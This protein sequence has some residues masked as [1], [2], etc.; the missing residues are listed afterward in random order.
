[1]QPLILASTSPFRRELLGKLGLP[2]QCASPDIDE[3]RHTDEQPA[4]LVARLAEQKAKAVANNHPNSLIIGS[5]QVAILNKQILGKPGNHTRATQ[6]LQQASGKIITFLTGLSLYNTTS[7][8]LQTDVVP[9][10]VYFRKLTN[11]QIESYLQKEQPYNCAGSFKSEGLGISL[12][13]K[14]QGDDPNTLI[15]LPLIRLIRMLNKEGV[16]VI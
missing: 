13:Q 12:F 10:T 2:F 9:Y 1:M 8:T 15:G 11:E 3:S 14:L 6:Q 4:A 5:D 7:H 16:E